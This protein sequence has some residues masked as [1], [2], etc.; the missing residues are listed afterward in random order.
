VPSD[1]A[2]TVWTRLIEAGAVPYGLEAMGAMRIEKGHVAGPEINGQTTAADL[3]L[4][5]LVSTKKEFI[6]KTLL[7]RP[8][9]NDPARLALVGLVPED[10]KTPIRAGS[11]LVADPKVPPPVPMVGHVT[12]VTWSPT[13]GHPI[14]LALLASGARRMGETVVAASPMSGDFVPVRVV[15]P[16]FFDPEGARQNG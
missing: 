8:G 16:H 2:V 14:A 9:L 11:Q 1:D 12:S 6:G 10:R 7:R 15:S 5:K 4:G 3:G 13:L